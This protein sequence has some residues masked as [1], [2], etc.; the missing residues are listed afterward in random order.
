MNSPPREANNNNHPKLISQRKQ[1]SLREVKQLSNNQVNQRIKLRAIQLVVSQSTEKIC[2]LYKKVFL[3]VATLRKWQKKMAFAEKELSKVKVQIKA[4]AEEALAD[5]ER[6]DAQ[7]QRLMGKMTNHYWTNKNSFYMLANEHFE[8]TQQINQIVKY[9]EAVPGNLAVLALANRS[10]KSR[11]KVMATL[12]KM[13]VHLSLLDEKLVAVTQ[14]LEICKRCLYDNKMFLGVLKSQTSKKMRDKIRKA[15]ENT[16][17]KRSVQ[18]K[19]I[20]EYTN[21]DSNS[22]PSIVDIPEFCQKVDGALEKFTNELDFDPGLKESELKKAS[23][24]FIDDTLS[25]SLDK[26]NCKSVSPI[27]VPARS[28]PHSPA[29]FISNRTVERN[30]MLSQAL[31]LQQAQK[32]TIRYS[33]DWK[34]FVEALDNINSARKRAQS[35]SGLD[36]TCNQENRIVISWCQEI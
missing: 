6:F 4:K 33:Q 36:N 28:H 19:K 16:T 2:K 27:L 7:R 23:T 11:R 9:A 14:K 5:L 34:V 10:V 32:S 26:I 21:S 25:S 24:R 3:K 30:A 17:S 18:G 1:R 29:Y 22:S 31:V 15:E 13:A 35:L 8:G 20:L 12:Q